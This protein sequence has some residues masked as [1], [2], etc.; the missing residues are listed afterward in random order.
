MTSIINSKAAKNKGKVVRSHR[1]IVDN[2]I[3]GLTTTTGSGGHFLSLKMLIEVWVNSALE[4]EGNLY[5]KSKGWENF[6]NTS[7]RLV[8]WRAKILL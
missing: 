5:G 6:P 3:G 4:K 8:I 7:L 1:T 2:I